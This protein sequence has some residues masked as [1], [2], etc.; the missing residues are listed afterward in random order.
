MMMAPID[1]IKRKKKRQCSS[2]QFSAVQYDTKHRY[3]DDKVV[4]VDGN[5]HAARRGEEKRQTDSKE[6]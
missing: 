2:V 3:P 4:Q 5:M 6:S 1:V